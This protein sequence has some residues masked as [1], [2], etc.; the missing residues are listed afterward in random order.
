MKLS[1]AELRSLNFAKDITIAKLSADAS[2]APNAAS[3][4]EIGEMFT[5]IY[6]AILAI[7]DKEDS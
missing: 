2:T 4:K 5:E 3:G 6:K 1:D 7:A